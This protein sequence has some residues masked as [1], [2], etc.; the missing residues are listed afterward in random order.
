MKTNIVIDISP[1]ILFLATFSSKWCYHFGFVCPGMPKLSKITS[2]LFFCNILRKR[3][4]MSYANNNE[5]LLD[6]MKL[7]GWSSILKA[8]KI[9]IL[10]YLEKKL[11]MK[12]IFCMQINTKVCYKLISTFWASKVPIRWYY[13]D[14]WAWSSIL[15]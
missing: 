2:L 11:K 6:T 1:P 7:M 10:Q 14:W 13:H 3:W 8:P 9:V 5:I 12:L 15:K 4:V